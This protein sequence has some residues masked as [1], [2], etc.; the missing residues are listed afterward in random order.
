MQS[1]PAQP[2]PALRP[3]S[4]VE[5]GRI[6]LAVAEAGA[7]GDPLLLVHGFTGA[8]EDFDDWLEP[9]AD[10]GWHVVAPDLRGHGFSDKPGAESAYSLD[11]F[12]ED[13]L[14]LVD[15]LGWER[16]RLLGHSMGGMIAQRLALACAHRLDAFVLMDTAPAGLAHVPADQ[17]AAAQHVVRM[18]GMDA[19]E[20]ALAGGAG[21]PRAAAQ[22]RVVATRP[23]YAAF[24]AEKLRR[25][26]PAM[27][28]AMA[29]ELTSFS[30]MTPQLRTLAV[31]T[32]VVL[33]EDDEPFR[34]PSERL[35]EAIPGAHLTVVPGAAHSPQ[36][37]NPAVWWEVV[38][39]FLAETRT[40]LAVSPD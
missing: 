27:Y 10:A 34:L 4:P 9:L 18:H 31:P 33:G 35:V 28:A 26:S 24:G 37:E 8:K 12:T 36:F 5:L 32:M 2:S 20:R 13:L 30:D 40:G 1:G 14:A 17:Q 7:G 21:P 19:L 3:G 23:G 6:R 15:H 39:S 22:E 25:A 11:L 38:S 29:A 16:F